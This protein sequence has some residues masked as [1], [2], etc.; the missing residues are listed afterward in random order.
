MGVTIDV[1]PNTALADLD[2]ALRTLLK[3]EL[4][5]QG[6]D[7][8]EISFDAPSR[9]WS[10][11]LTGPT[12][13]L[14]LYDLREARDQAAVS[15]TERRGNGLAVVTPPSLRLEATYAITAWSKAVEDEHR[16]LSQ[17]ISILHSYREL[18]PDLLGPR[19]DDAGTIETLVG[20]PL[21]EKADFWTAVGG[22]YKP[23]VDFALRLSIASGA[24]YRRGPEV[25]TQVVRTA[26]RDRPRG[27][28]VEL[29]RFGGTISDG[30]G[31]PIA[32]AWM[33]LPA[34]GVWTSSDT[35]GRFIFDRVRPGDY[36][37]RARTA[38]GA[39]MQAAISIPGDR[40]DLIVEPPTRKRRR[41][42]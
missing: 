39:E 16:L 35:A 6:F 5:R 13:S 20:R 17:M 15:P 31:L 36:E 25:R 7:G 41:N 32:N 21:E 4:G 38:A 24:S 19:L 34:L 29:L 30:D 1:Q 2:E 27:Q 37:L 33:A 40:V 9:D 14:F 8:V 3:R 23:S 22:Q 11:K 28:V 18:P 42:A 26:D 10:G 12:V